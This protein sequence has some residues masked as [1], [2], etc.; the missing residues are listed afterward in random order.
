[1]NARKIK[2]NQ[3]QDY[4]A[5]FVIILCVTNVEKKKNII[6]WEIYLIKLFQVIKQ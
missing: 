3:N 6:N 4:I 2:Q 1:M 5:Q